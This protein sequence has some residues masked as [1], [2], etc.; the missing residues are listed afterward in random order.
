M[1][2][3]RNRKYSRRPTAGEWALGS[4][5]VLLSLM[6][7]GGGLWGLSYLLENWW[8]GRT[9]EL[10][11]LLLTLTVAGSIFSGTAYF[12]LFTR[13]RRRLMEQ[14]SRILVA[15]CD[16]DTS[17]GQAQACQDQQAS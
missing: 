17:P 6:C 7:F 4:F 9:W 13:P 8:F 14:A 12:L 5:L 3:R 2:R 16:K 15:T 11:V 1:A 10:G